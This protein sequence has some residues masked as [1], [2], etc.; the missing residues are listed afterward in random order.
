MST[1]EPPAGESPPREPPRRHDPPADGPAAP[2]AG[3]APAASA[4]PPTWR[5][6]A[7]WAAA[8]VAL[9]LV[10]VAGVPW[11]RSTLTTV[12]TNDAY[13]NG[14][15]TFV[16]P[17]VP[18]QVKRVLVDD[19]GRVRAGDLLRCSKGRFLPGASVGPSHAGRCWG[20]RRIPGYKFTSKAGT[21][22]G[23]IAAKLRAGVQDKAQ[24]QVKAKGIN[25]PLPALQLTLPVTVQLLIGDANGTNCWQSTFTTQ[26]RND[27]K[28]FKAKGP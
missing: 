4:T 27:A 14:H 11:L 16:A 1:P 10:L 19:N 23:V 26:V 17:R 22:N 5:R 25:V 24:V 9:V 8:G 3:E 7:Q 13:V 6:R 20:T 21:P 18:G 15:V 28:Q 2:G 12:S